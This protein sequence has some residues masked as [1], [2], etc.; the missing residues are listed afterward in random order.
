MPERRSG[1]EGVVRLVFAPPIPGAADAPS[2]HRCTGSASH[3]AGAPADGRHGVR[4]PEPARRAD[5][6]AHM[7]HRMVPGRG[8]PAAAGAPRVSGGGP[9]DDDQ[10]RVLRGRRRGRGRPLGERLVAASR[11]I[12]RSVGVSGGSGNRGRRRRPPGLL[13]RRRDRRGPWHR[14]PGRLG[15]SGR[16][17]TVR[18]RRRR[19]G[20]PGRLRGRMV[21]RR[22]HRPSSARLRADGHGGAR[23]GRLL[24]PHRRDHRA[25]PRRP[26]GALL[27]LD[28]QLDGRRDGPRPRCG[29]ARG[30]VPVA[31]GGPGLGAGPDGHLRDRRVCQRSLPDR[32]APQRHKGGGQLRLPGRQPLGAEAPRA[33]GHTPG[34]HLRPERRHGAARRGPGRHPASRRG[35]GCRQRGTGHALDRSRRSRRGR[36][37]R[38]CIARRG[39]GGHAD[40][41]RPSAAAVRDLREPVLQRLRS[42][43][44]TPRG[45]QAGQ[46]RRDLR[47]GHCGQA[48][49]RHRARRGP[50][51][52]GRGV[53]HRVARGG[54]RL[55][56]ARARLR[57]DDPGSERVVAWHRRPDPGLPQRHILVRPALAPS[58]VRC[59][60][61]GG[62]APDLVA[63]AP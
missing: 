23:A 43:T 59:G 18:P 41:G 37:G 15:R 31:A 61:A 9:G 24:A 39:P 63:G 36:P 49:R 22:D 62:C 33:G 13:R 5:G 45:G 2:L 1:G 52:P 53:D 27:H 6:A 21:V 12:H 35:V 32:L 40:G 58:R 44:D 54:R 56:V 26:A 20:R 51:R 48:D 11:L 50:R 16:R 47:G 4:P 7:G 28:P 8:V 19:P 14:E 3:G 38:H 60:R 55:L 42:G 17:R 34:G 57:S 10:S 25:L 46:G 29:V 30:A